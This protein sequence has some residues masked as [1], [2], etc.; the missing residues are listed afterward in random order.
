MKELCIQY[1]HGKKIHSLRGATLQQKTESY[2]SFVD[3]FFRQGQIRLHQLLCYNSSTMQGS[4]HV[5][6]IVAI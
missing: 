6:L 3:V 4:D 5:V 2:S 1:F